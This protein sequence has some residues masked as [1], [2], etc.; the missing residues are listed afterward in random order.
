MSQADVARF[1]LEGHHRETWAEVAFPA[2]L[3]EIKDFYEKIADF[4]SNAIE[5]K[6]GSSKPNLEADNEILESIKK[7]FNEDN[8]L[9]KTTEEL[10]ELLNNLPNERDEAIIK[11]AIELT[12]APLAKNIVE[13]SSS[14]L[15]NNEESMKKNDSAL[16]NNNLDSTNTKTGITPS[17]EVTDAISYTPL[18]QNVIGKYQR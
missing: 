6:S 8:L 18:T 13:A 7:Y 2:Q 3:A 16:Q 12:N 14:S 10:Q 1:L 17:A 15:L 4:L 9:E 5:E 11:K